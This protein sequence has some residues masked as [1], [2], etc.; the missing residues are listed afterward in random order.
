[1]P[2]KPSSNA[3]DGG[4]S[5]QRAWAAEDFAHLRVLAQAVLRYRGRLAAAFVSS[6]LVAVFSIAGIAAI[7]PVLDIIFGATEFTPPVTAQV[8]DD[9]GRLTGA[10]AFPGFDPESVRVERN[11]TEIHFE[12]DVPPEIRDDPEAIRQWFATEFTRE[13]E[14]WL[15]QKTA[16]PGQATVTDGKGDRL[17]QAL[18][19]IYSLLLRLSI[20]NQYKALGLVAALLVVLT[21]LK[22]AATYAQEY[23]TNWIGR[24]VVM[25]LRRRLYEHVTALPL[26]FFQREKAGSLLSYLTVDVE[27]F[28]NSTMAVFGRMLQEPILILGMV[29]GLSYAAPWLT[30]LYALVLPILGWIMTEFGR[31][32]RKARRQSQDA[33]S[34]MS[35]ILQ[36]TFS[37]IRVVRAFQMEEVQ[38]QKF[39]KE[40]LAIFR[41]FMKVIRARALSSPL[42]ET[43]A[44]LGVAAVL[45]IGGYV[46]LQHDMEAST[47]IV[48]LVGLGSLYQPVKRLN[49]AYESVQQGLAGADRIFEIL[50]RPTEPSQ[51]PNVARATGMEQGL[52]FDHVNHRYG[53]GPLVIKEVTFTIPKGRVTALVG[54]SGAGK[55]TLAGLVPRLFDPTE[56][57]LL[58]DGVD[59]RDVV[60]KDLRNLIGM[61]PQE[62]CLFHDTV[63][64]NVACGQT[65]AD[66]KSIVSALQDAQAWEFVEDLPEGIHTVIGERAT[67]LSGGQAQRI[68]VARAFYRNPPILI[69]D[70][71]TSS[72]DSASE[73]LVR[74][75]LD[76]LMEDRTVL[77][78]AHRLST[79]IRAD[80]IVVLNRGEIAGVGPHGDLLDTCPIY[81][82]LYNLQL[83]TTTNSNGST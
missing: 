73:E 34:T 49:K 5:S 81:E 32:I 52:A 37:G 15:R 23:L 46:V 11:G 21:V 55:S 65:D 67:L 35:G 7:K 2:T 9:S 56:G 14:Q 44:S 83:S 58:L 51:G 36:E 20:E 61:V 29:A 66:E 48:Y 62:I 42:I 38:H 59:V 26:G 80:Q 1:M 33:I 22:G 78:I 57:A 75:A 41:S 10:F 16:P 50:D 39:S 43:L 64:S 6:I 12:A 45:M 24:R 60:L 8:Q 17:R 72:L 25:D 30:L 3:P 63:A 47:F 79:I 76:R 74:L 40:N 54:P 19:P 69:L 28:G 68:A 70:E 4:H 13:R 71:A 77:V 31:R 27:L 82:E 53:D 18:K